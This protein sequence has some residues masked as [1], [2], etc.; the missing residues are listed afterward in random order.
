MQEERTLS[1]QGKVLGVILSLFS[2]VGCWMN[3]VIPMANGTLNWR[4]Q[5]GAKDGTSRNPV[6]ETEFIPDSKE[7]QRR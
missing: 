5:V 7:C 4:R 3:F 2:R 6:N 1:V